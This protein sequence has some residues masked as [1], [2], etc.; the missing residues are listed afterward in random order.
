M[1]TLVFDTSAGGTI[2][3]LYDDC[4]MLDKIEKIME[5]GQAEE[6]A[7]DVDKM[8]KKQQLDFQNVELLGVCVGPGSF[9]GVRAGLA[10]ARGLAFASPNLKITGVNAFEVYA[11]MLK[12]S[13]RANYNAVV[14]ET[15]REDFYFQ[16]FDK[17]LKK[18]C[19]PTALTREKILQQLKNHQVSFIGDGVERLLS[20]AT[21]LQIKQV[22]LLEIIDVK[23]LFEATYQKYLAKTLDFSKPLYIRGADACVK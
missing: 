13:D 12:E 2:I 23:A 16:L 14:I 17:E 9:T 20:G 21:G 19:E 11:R 10:F 18:V 6:L 15:K 1:Y 7:V 3:G 22:D 4:L 8:L 5:F